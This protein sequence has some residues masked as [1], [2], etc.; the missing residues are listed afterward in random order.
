MGFGTENMNISYSYDHTFAGEIMP[1][2][3]GTHEL[4][5]SFRINN[6]YR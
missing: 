5:I 4:G 2:T 6:G 3:Y 1:Y